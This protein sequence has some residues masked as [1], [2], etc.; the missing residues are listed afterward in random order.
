M[1]C[2]EPFSAPAGAGPVSGRNHPWPVERDVQVNPFRGYERWHELARG[3]TLPEVSSLWLTSFLGPY[4]HAAA[5]ISN[6]ISSG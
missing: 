5:A 3:T 1:A 4:D 6:Q 2:S